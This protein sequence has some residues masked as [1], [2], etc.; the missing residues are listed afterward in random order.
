[1]VQ[2]DENRFLTE[3]S[4]LFERNKTV[5]SVWIS[6]KRSNNKPRKSKNPSKPEDYMCIV[7]AQAGKKEKK[8]EI[9][10]LVSA[11]QYPKFQNSMTLIMKASMDV[12]KK[13]AKK[14]KK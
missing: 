8:R 4:K 9:S 1:M 11:A 6:M 10:T 3:L 14:D 7:R 5:G 12:L 13:K 2:C